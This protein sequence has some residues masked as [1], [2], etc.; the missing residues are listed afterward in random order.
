[1]CTK[2][3]QD[4]ATANRILMAITTRELRRSKRTQLINLKADNYE[5]AID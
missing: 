5:K 1:M 3:R 2:F 4:I